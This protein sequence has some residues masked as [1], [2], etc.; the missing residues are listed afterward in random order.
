MDFALRCNSL[1]CRAVLIE[2]AVVTTCRYV[3]TPE[4]ASSLVLLIVSSSHI[5]CNAC[6]DTL[7]LSAP[8]GGNRVCP[9]CQT[10][11]PN[12]DDAVSTCLKP[13][14]DYKTSV[15]SGLTPSMIMECAGRAL[16]FWCYQS[17]QEMHVGCFPE[18]CEN[19]DHVQSIPRVSCK[20]PDGEVQSSQRS[21]G[22]ACQ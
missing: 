9:A 10:R 19:A 14:D 15:L 17:T 4:C 20:K 18:G 2:R 12:P 1:K 21:N 22:Q 11:L 5:F 7:G 8:P 3:C 6:S 13:T 16:S